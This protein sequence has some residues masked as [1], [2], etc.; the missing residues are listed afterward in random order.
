[1]LIRDLLWEKIGNIQNSGIFCNI[2]KKQYFCRFFSREVSSLVQLPFSAIISY[3]ES[4]F[5]QLV[6]NQAKLA[7]VLTKFL[8]S[9]TFSGHNR[10]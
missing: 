8:F 10:N 7:C 4:N 3:A 5:S 9:V 2:Y 6:N 1:M